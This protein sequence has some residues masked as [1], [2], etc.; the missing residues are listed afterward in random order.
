MAINPEAK[1]EVIRFDWTCSF[2]L[3]QRRVNDILAQ[4]SL[5]KMLCEKKSNDIGDTNWAVMKEKDAGFNR[6]CVSD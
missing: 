1:F 2:G 4:Q 5:Q 6:L 3:W